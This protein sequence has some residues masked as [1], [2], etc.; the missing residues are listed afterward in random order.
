MSLYLLATLTGG[1]VMGLWFDRLV[2]GRSS[3]WPLLAGLAALGTCLAL[4]QEWAGVALGCIL[5]ARVLPEQRPE[6]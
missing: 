4:G 5:G 2:G 3:A 6:R 1:V